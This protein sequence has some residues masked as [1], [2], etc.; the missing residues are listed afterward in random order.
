MSLTLTSGAIGVLVVTLWIIYSAFNIESGLL[1][2][3]LMAA[4]LFA[5]SGAVIEAA[6]PRGSSSLKIFIIIIMLTTAAS[7]TIFAYTILYESNNVAGLETTITTAA[8]FSIVTFTTLGYGDIYPPDDL[9]IFAATQAL[10]GYVYLGLVVGLV[11][12]VISNS[13]NRA[14]TNV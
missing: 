4:S 9:R 5:V 1:W 12:N 6:S 11:G 8:Y 13:K 14:K 2:I 10:L 3:M 7:N